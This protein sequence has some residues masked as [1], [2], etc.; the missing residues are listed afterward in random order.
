MIGTLLRGSLMEA[1]R[2][3]GED[4]EAVGGAFKG[5]SWREFVDVWGNYP[6]AEIFE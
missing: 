3:R 1:F 5:E 2:Q 6:M 4:V